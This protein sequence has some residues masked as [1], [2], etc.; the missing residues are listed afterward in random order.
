MPIDIPPM[1]RYYQYAKDRDIPLPVLTK[2]RFIFYPG[3]VFSPSALLSHHAMCYHACVG[4]ESPGHT[5]I[6]APS[7]RGNLK[8]FT[9][10]NYP[11]GN[12]I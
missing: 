9:Q 8:V 10:C 1:F 5:V 2:K 6:K 7:Y 11:L 3:K 12:G 4:K